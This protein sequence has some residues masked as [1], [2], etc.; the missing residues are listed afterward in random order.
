M[1]NIV[2]RL[3]KTNKDNTDTT[4]SYES[5]VKE[6][7]ILFCKDKLNNTGEII[8]KNNFNLKIIITEVMLWNNSKLF[9]S[10]L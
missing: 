2:I 6:N 3:I 8:K 10:K 9:T 5:S 1:N 7:K 4:L